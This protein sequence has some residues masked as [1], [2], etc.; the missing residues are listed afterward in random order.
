[1]STI[2]PAST[3]AVR[4]PSPLDTDGQ[5]RRRVAARTQMLL[6]AGSGVA[7]LAASSPQ[8]LPFA[9]RASV[10]VSNTLLYPVLGALLGTFLLGPV[11]TVAGGV[12][13]WLLAR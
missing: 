6:D 4:Q 5:R 9:A 11:G 1:M 2:L 7:A 3:Y 10:H 12:A 13:G 8:Q